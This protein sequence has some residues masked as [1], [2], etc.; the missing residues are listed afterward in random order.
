M[1]AAQKKS[2]NI[3]LNAEKREVFGKKLTGL[4]AEH[5]VP[6]NIYGRDFTSTAVTIDGKEL[7]KTYHVAGETQVL[8]LILDKQDLPVLI[9]QIQL[10]PTSDSILHVDFKK[11]DLT[12]K[13]EAH[14]PV[15]IV[16]E[17][18]AVEQKIGDLINPVDTLTV[19]GLP[20]KI[21]TEIEVDV[22]AL[23]EVDAAIKVSAIKAPTGVTLMDDPDTVI[24]KIAEHKEEELEPEVPA[25]GE[26]GEDAAEGEA[27][28][29]GGEE[30]PAEGD[31]PAEEAKEE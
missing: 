4:R 29:E 1:T 7:L 22:S 24:A 15:L 9:S 5:K 21:P 2:E 30:A 28:A 26:E 10:D 23:A 20:D 18:P 8:H 11:I 27:P 14:V 19:Q 6:G 25:E 12:K 16:G 13:I 31:A 3:T 17:A